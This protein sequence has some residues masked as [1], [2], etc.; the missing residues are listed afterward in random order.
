MKLKISKLIVAAAAPLL[1]QNFALAADS[2]AGQAA[3]ELVFTVDMS[4]NRCLLGIWLEQPAGEFVETVFVSNKLGQKGLANRGGAIDDKKGGSR[5][6]SLPVWAYHRGID[7]GNG[8]FNPPKDRPLPDAVSGATPRA[9]EFTWSYRPETALP[10]GKYYYFVEVNKSFD[11]N[12]QHNYSWYRGQP[13]VI[14]RGELIL[15][16]QSSVTAAAI[17]GHGH[18]AG[19]DGSI[20]PDIATLTSALDLIHAVN[21]TIIP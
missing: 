6:S 2:P 19:A 13:S 7:Y 21:V 1:W 9:G 16:E 10:Y 18:P 20:N 17:I 5:I 8:N 4:E 11:N 12:D 15:G 3:P 14:W